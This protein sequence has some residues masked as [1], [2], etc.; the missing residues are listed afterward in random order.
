[1]KKI[2]LTLALMV[3]AAGSQACNQGSAGERSSEKQAVISQTNSEQKVDVYY[4][5]FT[6]RCVSCVNVQN[7]T[8]RVLAENYS[9]DIEKGTIVYHEINLSEPDS[10]SIAQ[11]LG[12]GGQALLVVSGDK[13]YDLT[14]QGFM[15]ASRDYDRFKE[16]LDSAI[17]RVKT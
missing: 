5:H 1:M 15:Y 17:S 4:F 12:V 2:I 9:E 8:E 6:R 11:M 14:M 10:Q 16:T 13:K 7:A 3:I